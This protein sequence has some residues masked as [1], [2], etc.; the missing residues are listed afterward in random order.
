MSTASRWTTLARIVSC[1]EDKANTIGYHRE[2]SSVKTNLAKS[3]SAV[4]A[5]YSKVSKIL[6]IQKQK[7]NTDE[8]KKQNKENKKQ[9]K[10]TKN[11]GYL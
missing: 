8:N 1:F 5:I 10:N 2:D 9:N 4:D 11:N 7:Q 6:Y 3:V